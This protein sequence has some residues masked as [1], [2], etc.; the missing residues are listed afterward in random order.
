MAQHSNYWFGTCPTRHTVTAGL[1]RNVDVLIIGGGIAGIS[2]LYQ[3]LQCGITNAYLIEDSTIGFHASGRNSGQLMIRGAKPFSSMEEKNG[4]DY[5]QFIVQNNRRFLNGLRNVPFDTDLRDTGGLRLATTTEEFDVLK[6]E[7]EFLQRHA[8]I[9]CPI[10]NANQVDS[11]LPNTKCIGGIFV[12]NEAIFNPYKVV[13]GMREY[14]ERNGPRVLT[15]CQVIHV[16]RTQSEGF[17]V[18]I[19]HKGTIRAK[20][21][22]YCTNAYTPELVPELSQTMIG[23]RGQMIATDFISDDLLRSVPQSGMS[24]NGFNEYWRL[25]GGRLLVGGM[26]Q[27]VRGNQFDILEDGEISSSVY[28]KLRTF[29][30]ETLPMFKD[31]KFTHTWSGIM[32]ATPDQMPLIGSLPDRPDEYILGGFNGYGFSHALQ[33]S[34]II[35]DLITEGESSCPGVDLFNPVRFHNKI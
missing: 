14:I 4:I 27:A 16:V 11:M 26:R 1:V 10:L 34:V 28:D 6:K 13:N 31:I 25:H 24:C 35:K 15:G 9:Q 5:L 3:L 18:A 29:V 32:C 17:S 33:G 7:S 19:R 12:P 8:S 22:V 21:I 2:V 30:N 23:F 20:K